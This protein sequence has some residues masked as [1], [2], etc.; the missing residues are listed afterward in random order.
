MQAKEG[1]FVWH[2]SGPVIFEAKATSFFDKEKQKLE[3]LE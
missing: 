2:Q 3:P 1:R